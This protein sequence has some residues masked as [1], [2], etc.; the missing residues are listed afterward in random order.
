MHVIQK[1]K[2]SVME[3]FLV[4]ISEHNPNYYN[5]KKNIPKYKHKKNYLHNAL[6][7]NKTIFLNDSLILL[8]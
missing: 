2:N 1:L 7:K 6:K 3:I 4:L 8:V 5:N